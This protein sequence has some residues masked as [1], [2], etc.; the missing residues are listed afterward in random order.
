MM[1]WGTLV[2]FALAVAVAVAQPV[3][4]VLPNGAKLITSPEPGAPWVIAMA[5]LKAGED[6]DQDKPGTRWVTAQAA[7]RRHALLSPSELQH[8]SAAV[9]GGV[10]LFIER[11]HLRYEVYTTGKWLENALFLLGGAA[12]HGELTADEVEAAKNEVKTSITAPIGPAAEA[13][14]KLLLEAFGGHPFGTRPT[15]EQVDAVTIQDCRDY[16]ARFFRPNLL[17]LVIAGEVP[18]EEALRVAR[19][20]LGGWTASGP[21]PSPAPDILPPEEP[22]ELVR[23]ASTTSAYLAAGFVGPPPASKDFPAFALVAAALGKGETS[24]L[25]RTMRG[26]GAAYQVGT[27]LVP[28]VSG[29]LL[30]ATVQFSPFEVD[31]TTHRPEVVLTKTR[32]LAKDA[33]TSLAKDGLGAAELASVKRRLLVDYQLADPPRAMPAPFVQGHQRLRDRAF[34][35]GWWE[36]VGCGYEMDVGFPKAVEQVTA[37]ELLSVARKYCSRPSSVLVVPLEP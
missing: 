31:P 7:Y 28:T 5:F 12:K 21:E 6:T 25:A 15:L 32:E 3:R 20:T 26:S 34:W 24:V 36:M 10:K 23:T 11:D 29:S 18:G 27:G 14:N 16:Y 2:V 33:L 1:R 19:Q 8:I 35:L 37:E 9:G 13:V 4:T 17:T 30:F 22:F